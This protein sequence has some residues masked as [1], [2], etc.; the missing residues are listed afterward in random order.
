MLFL[1]LNQLMKVDW[2]AQAPVGQEWNYFQIKHNKMFS[3]EGTAERFA[4]RVSNQIQH[5]NQRFLNP[6]NK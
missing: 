2:V 4:S 5:L 3:N 1:Q 6:H